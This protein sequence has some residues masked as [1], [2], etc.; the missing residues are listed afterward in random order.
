MEMATVIETIR[1]R[2]VCLSLAG[3]CIKAASPDGL[4]DETR[5]LIKQNKPEIITWLRKEQAAPSKPR[6][7]DEL[8]PCPLCGGR[9]FIHGHRGGFF[10]VSCQ[11]SIKGEPVR[12]GGTGWQ[13]QPVRLQPRVPDVKDKPTLP[14]KEWADRHHAELMAA[15][16]TDKELYKG[17][18]PLAGGQIWKRPGLKVTLMRDGRVVFTYQ[19]PTGSQITQTAW[20]MNRENRAWKRTESS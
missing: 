9:S 14:G 4:D 15:G 13:E 12:A 17:N 1:D 19:N 18:Y 20:P 16:W 8:K 7:V 5:G 11:P 6:V 2:G 10:C 3:D